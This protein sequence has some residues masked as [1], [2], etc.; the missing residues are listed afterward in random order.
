MGSEQTSE[1]K[2][3]DIL[4]NDAKWRTVTVD[5]VNHKFILSLDNDNM[6]SV[7]S[8]SLVAN[9]NTSQSDLIDCFRV[10]SRYELPGKCSS[11]VETCFRYFDLNGPLVLGRQ[12]NLDTKSD[13]SRQET[14]LN[15]EGC[16]S[17]LFV[18]ERLVDLGSEAI[19]DHQTEIGCGV[20]SNNNKVC[21]KR[22]AE[23]ERCEQIWGDQVRCDRVSDGLDI[24]ADVVS[25]RGDGYLTLKEVEMSRHS[26]LKI[27]FYLK[28]SREEG[29]VS[30]RREVVAFFEVAGKGFYLDYDLRTNSLE[31][32][33]TDEKKKLFSLAVDLDDGFWN[34]IR[35]EFVN[36][37]LYLAVNDLLKASGEFNYP[38]EMLK[39]FLGGSPKVKAGGVAGCIKGVNQKLLLLRGSVNVV[40]GCHIDGQKRGNLFN[41]VLKSVESPLINFVEIFIFNSE[42]VKLKSKKIYYRYFIQY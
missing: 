27:E 26:G 25:L 31:L 14:A 32:I 30:G 12:S 6:P 22:K 7:D 17:D 5:Y 2:I 9:R 21:G 28:M 40:K 42:F 3:E 13:L 23:C 33:K 19:S 8:C 41:L 24:E 1:I 37:R 16:I 20:K 35:L 4:V 15:Y 10:E 38:D 34:R 18:N 11:Q 39:G 29:F 36:G